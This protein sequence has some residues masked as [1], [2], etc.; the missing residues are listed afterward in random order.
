MIDLYTWTT[1]NGRKVSM[2]LEEVGLPY[3][4][5][6]IDISKDEQ[7]SRFKAREE[8]PY[9]RW[10]LGDDE[11][12]AREDAQRRLAELGLAAFEALA[13][14]AEQSGADLRWETEATPVLED[15]R[16]VGVRR[17]GRGAAAELRARRDRSPGCDRDVLLGSDAAADL[18]A[19]ERLVETGAL[20]RAAATAIT[21]PA[22]PTAAA[23]S[24]PER[25]RSPANSPAMTNT[26]SL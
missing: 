3:E 22:S 6:A 8:T 25:A 9:K 5:H 1:P 2:M 10:K 16:V 7:L 14:A 15:G 13:E 4:S 18:D 19:A 12:S 24:H 11:Y 17:A 20:A 21:R 23:G 26:P